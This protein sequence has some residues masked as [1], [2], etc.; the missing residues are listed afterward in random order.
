MKEFLENGIL[1][2]V[3]IDN[4][5]VSN[6]SLVNE[7]EFVQK[8]YGTSDEMILKMMRNAVKTAFATDDVKDRML[9]KIKKE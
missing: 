8:M 3:N 2:S 5:T 6:T 9:R 7:L 1:V 4:R